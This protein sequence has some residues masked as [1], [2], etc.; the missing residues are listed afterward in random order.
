MEQEL[1]IEIELSTDKSGGLCLEFSHN[2]RPPQSLGFST[3]E[4]KLMLQLG[5]TKSIDFSTVGEFGI[6]FKIWTLL[7]DVIEIKH[8]HGHVV[9]QMNDTIQTK[10]VS[11]KEERFTVR[12]IGAGKEQFFQFNGWNESI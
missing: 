4:L 1:E 6:G 3:N 10:W 8:G 9:C 11:S 7:F 5:G 12:L 2:G